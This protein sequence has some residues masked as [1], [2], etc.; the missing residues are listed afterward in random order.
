[1]NRLRKSP[2]RGVTL[3][4]M[5]VA[6]VVGGVLIAMAGMFVRRQIMSYFDVA[7][8]A[9]L[10]DI[11][12]GALRRIARDVQGA[13]PNSLRPGAVNSS[14]LEFVP[15]VTAG[16]FASQDLPD[17]GS[18]LAVQG[19]PVNVAAGQQLV[20]CNTGQALA[21]VYAGNNR[22]PLTAGAALSSLAFGGAAITDY[23]SSNRFHV[24]GQSVVY[25]FEGG[26][27]RTLWRF[28]RCS[29]QAVQPS[30]IAALTAN[31]TLKAALATSVDSVRFNYAANALP[32][33]G[34]LSIGL[35][36]SASDAPEE[37]VT[38]LQQVNLPNSP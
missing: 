15:L 1:M 22:R 25:A 11:A 17:L 35:V 33:L 36:L 4:E 7:R 19:P 23:C 3:I 29:L 30:T 32:S 34:I 38:L 16:R 27:V 9:E 14:F 31:C 18:P 6:I 20:V 37:R 12:D 8:R 21:E 28:S 13:L 10:S 26:G 2:Q 24:V 5:I